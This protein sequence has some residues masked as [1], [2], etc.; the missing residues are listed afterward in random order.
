MG[1]VLNLGVAGCFVLAF[2]IAVSFGQAVAQSATQTLVQAGDGSL[3][4]LISGTKHRIAPAPIDD[5]VLAS[6]PEGD[7]WINGQIDGAPPITAV[8][9]VPAPALAPPAQPTWQRVGAWSGSDK[10]NTQQFTISGSQQRVTYTLR[11]TRSGGQPGMCLVFH[12]PDGGQQD[13]SCPRS[14]NGVWTIYLPN[15][16]YSMELDP[17]ST[18]YDVTLEDL[19]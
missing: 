12:R 16:T 18:R 15:G 13:Y 9:E 3:W 4:V 14:E 8:A 17:V 11:S 1:K 7:A 6:L 19:R 10:N 2:M 5:A